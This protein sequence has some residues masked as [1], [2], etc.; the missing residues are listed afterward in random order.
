MIFNQKKRNLIVTSGDGCLSV[1]DI[2][3]TTPIM[4]SDN[5]DEELSSVALVRNGSKVAVGTQE[6]VLGLFK[7]GQFGDVSDRF[8]G[9]PSSIESLCKIN[10]NTLIAG[11][12]DGHIR[13]ISLY[14]HSY[15]GKVGKHG[16]LPVERVLLT[17]DKKYLVSLAQDSKIKFWNTSSIYQKY[18]QKISFNYDSDSSSGTSSNSDSATRSDSGSDSDSDSGSDSDT[19]SAFVQPT[20]NPKKNTNVKNTNVNAASDSD[21]DSGFGSDA[22]SHSH[23]ESGSEFVSTTIPQPGVS[24]SLLNIPAKRKQTAKPKN[25]SKAKLKSFFKDIN[26]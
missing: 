20:A 5:Q 24:S 10:E 17:W 1:Y 26:K 7:Y 6:G 21:S 18:D 12:G 4:V 3:K 25:T 19:N 2:R 16:A 13:V 14:P 8:P 15:S 9:N 23:S 11:G 22:N